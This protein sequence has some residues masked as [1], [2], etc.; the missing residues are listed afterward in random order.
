MTASLFG[1]GEVISSIL[2]HDRKQNTYKFALL[3]AINDTVFSF[4][5]MLG[6]GCDVAVPL[7]TLAR[8]WVAYYWPFTNSAGPIYQGQRRTLPEVL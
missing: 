3:R 5:D 7:R 6:H 1:V 8:Y 4:P 2:K